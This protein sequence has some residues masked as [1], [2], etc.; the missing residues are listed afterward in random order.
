VS[1]QQ[2]T[3]AHTRGGQ[4]GLGSGVTTADYNH[5]ELLL[6]FHGCLDLH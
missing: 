3:A 6:I 1:Q 2:R 5:V 4:A